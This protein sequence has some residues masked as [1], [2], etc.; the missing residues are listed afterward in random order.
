MLA[1]APPDAPVQFIDVRDLGEWI[2][3]AIEGA[4]SGVYNATGETTTFAQLLEACQRVSGN[5]DLVWVASE[6]LAQAGVGEWME[7]PLWIVSPDYAADAADRRL[8]GAP[9][10][11]SG[12]ARSTRPSATRSRGTPS[13]R[14]RGPK[15]SASRR[16]A[17]ASSS[18]VPEKD[19]S[20]TPLSKKLGAKPGTG[21]VV[22]FTTSRADL[23][24]RFA[25]LKRT[26]D[27]ADGLWVAW[28]KKASKI[29]TDLDFDTV[30]QIGLDAG[31]VDNKSAAIDGDW[32]AL[33]SSTGSATAS[34]S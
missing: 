14:L 17:N 1:P 24:R 25:K 4:R 32:Q 12:S 13:A 6:R 34:R 28:P 23:A 31:L 26:L 8:E 22:F 15:A 9:R 11:A 27:P 21:V 18:P 3:A 29:E 2:V 16:N 30:Q 33:G 5:V 20:S 7:L 10:T 19:Y